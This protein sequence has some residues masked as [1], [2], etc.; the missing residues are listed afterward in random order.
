[1]TEDPP[2]GFMDLDICPI[3]RVSPKEAVGLLRSVMGDAFGREKSEALWRWKHQ[4]NPMGSSLG[5]AGYS[6]QGQLI[7]LRPFMRWQL[8]DTEGANVTAARAVDTAV[9]PNW[10][11]SGLFSR[12]THLAVEALA[13]SKVSLIFNTP[14]DRSGPGYQKMGWKLLGHPKLWLALR[15][16]WVSRRL[17]LTDGPGLDGLDPYTTHGAS[18]EK[19]FLHKNVRQDLRVL[20]DA[21]FLDWRYGQHPNLRYFILQSAAAGAILREDRRKGRVGVAMVDYWL[22]DDSAHA[23]WKLLREVRRRTGGAYLVMGPLE[24]KPLRRAAMATGFLPV[25]WRNV[26]LAVRHVVKPDDIAA[27]REPSAWNLQLGDLETF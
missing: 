26:N 20:K 1:M 23:F 9:H 14:N 8:I 16:G 24:S 18:L 6:K 7:A 3:D 11:R 12:L 2:P 25:P 15:P 21:A 4:A 13:D 17:E 22:S 10:R 5:L 27:Y 19:S